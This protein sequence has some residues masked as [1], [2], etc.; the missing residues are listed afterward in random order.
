MSQRGLRVLLHA[1][2]IKPDGVSG[3]IEQFALGLVA[4]LGQL[5]DGDESYDILVGAE[6]PQWL[7]CYLGPRQRVIVSPVT[8]GRRA[9]VIH[10]YLKGPLNL[11]RAPLRLWGLP[12]RSQRLQRLAASLGAGVVHFLHQGFV[13]VGLPT[14]YCVFDLQ[15]R[16]FPGF[17]PLWQRLARDHLMSQGCRKASATVAISEWTKRDVA[18]QYRVNPEKIHVIRIPPPT[19]AYPA[20]SDTAKEQVVRKFAL[21]RGF[22]L[23]PAQTWP[24]KNHLRL[25]DAVQKLRRERNLEIPV[26]CTGLQNNHAPRIL[27]R[28]RELKLESLVR[29]LGFVSPT[30]LCCLYRLADCLVFPS[31]FEG[32]GLPVL[33]AFRE[34]TPVA[35]SAATSLPEYAGGAA[36]LFDPLSIESIAGALA[37]M[38]TD[39]SLREKLRNAGRKRVERFSWKDTAKQYRAV[40]RKLSG[41]TLSEEDRALMQTV[42]LDWRAAA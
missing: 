13:P 19:V 42:M 28:I 32:G 5:E 3:G 2:G 29:F 27:A 14:V 39:D 34:G 26:I 7:D 37:A 35:C 1:E 11:A 30:E 25:V 8:P 18:Q 40:Y 22:A 36:L 15:H 24:H 17:F 12:Q 9:G 4:A 16:H 6:R 31:I 23:Y 38:F 10:R 41:A 33:E 21:P 20:V